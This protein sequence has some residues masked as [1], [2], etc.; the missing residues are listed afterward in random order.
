MS[1]RP[2]A[3]CALK[4]VVWALGLD[5]ILFLCNIG[6]KHAHKQKVY[7]QAERGIVRGEG[8]LVGFGSSEWLTS[9]NLAPLFI[10]TPNTV[11]ENATIGN[12]TVSLKCV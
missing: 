4:V 8:L 11:G 9:S 7:M 1:R 10:M 3:V 6:R 5:Y 12:F 2:V